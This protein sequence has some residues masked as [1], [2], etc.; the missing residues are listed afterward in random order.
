MVSYTTVFYVH[1]IVGGLFSS[2][3]FL[4][5]M[6]GFIDVMS[7]GKL[8]PDMWHK[9]I[10]GIDCVTNMMIMI[11]CFFG[12]KMEPASQRMLAWSML[13]LSLGAIVNL[14]IYPTGDMPPPPAVVYLCIMTTLY[15]LAL[16][17]GEKG[18]KA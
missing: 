4:M 3:V 16:S 5:G 15:M 1:L 9:A 12:T 13:F 2:P 6:D 11:Q 17:G 10:F 8:K 14:Y 18:K 7:E